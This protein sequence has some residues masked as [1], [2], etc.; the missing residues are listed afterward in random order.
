MVIRGDEAVVHT[1]NIQEGLVLL[2][3]LQIG[4]VAMPTCHFRQL[5]LNDGLP[6]AA[7]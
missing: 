4:V 6:A 7:S 1:R 3:W 5:G 2:V